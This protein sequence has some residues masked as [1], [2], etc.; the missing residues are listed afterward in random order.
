MAQR[1]PYAL[2]VVVPDGRDRAGRVRYTH[3][4][5]RQLDRDSDEIARGLQGDR[6]RAA[7]P[8]PW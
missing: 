5:Y 3:L 1:Q 8:G 2:A 4:T 6:D 7:A